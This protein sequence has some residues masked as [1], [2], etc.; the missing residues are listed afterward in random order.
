MGIWDD[1]IRGINAL[2][3]LRKSEAEK[4]KAQTKKANNSKLRKENKDLKKALSTNS[5][6]GIIG[7]FTTIAGI[8]IG[9]LLCAYFPIQNS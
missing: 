1:A 3:N 9:Y 7:I 8:F 5:K 2:A 4:L 6:I